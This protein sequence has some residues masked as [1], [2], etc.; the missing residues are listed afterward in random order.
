[1]KTYTELE[2]KEIYAQLINQIGH[3]AGSVCNWSGVDTVSLED[4]KKAWWQALRE[5]GEEEQQ[6]GAY[7]ERERI[8]KQLLK[9]NEAPNTANS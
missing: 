6:C 7:R 1:M 4:W 9:E 5:Y 3:D 2:V 8:A